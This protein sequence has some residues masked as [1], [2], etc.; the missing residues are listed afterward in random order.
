[1]KLVR[2]LV[3]PL[4]ACLLGAV[5]SAD[6]S[7]RWRSGN[8]FASELPEEMPAAAR[9]VIETWAEWT[10][11]VG[12]RMT[13]SEDG[14]V[15]LIS[16]VHDKRRGRQMKLI[17]ETIRLFDRE[18]PA[19]AERKKVGAPVAD[20]GV[21]E[22]DPLP[23]DPEGDPH[24]WDDAG[25]GGG[26]A[27]EAGWFTWATWGAG[28]VPPDT[29]TVVLFVVRNPEDQAS[30]LGRLAE[31]APYLA[32][33]IEVAL[34]HSGFVLEQPLAGAWVESM[35]QKEEWHPDGELVNRVARLLLLRRFG[36]LPHWFEQGFAW[37]AEIELR[38]GVFC[39]PY[40]R[41][42]VFAT[43][44]TDWD[45]VVRGRLA[46]R[47]TRPLVLDE[48]AAWPPHTYS[49]TFGK[50]AW[51]AVTFLLH[52]H[53]DALPALLESFRVFRDADDRVKVSDSEWHRD[54]DYSI[55]LDV[56]ARLLHEHLVPDWLEQ[57]TR[58][59]REER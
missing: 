13:L 20:A 31:I 3:G 32:D 10:G 33:W 39:F 49:D 25:G 16:P 55:P 12:S 47:A 19:P 50:L 51:G 34:Q 24:P 44:H 35:S 43:E 59:L 5:T 56:Q 11:R 54:P 14:R 36:R 18:L 28:A 26:G 30:L 17:E 42:F 38:G 40:R 29:E 1:M 58:F 15:L 2:T 8:H 45:A 41:E 4:L 9:S 22:S 52:A 6:V 7:V 21:D 46:T 57:A 48:F 27:D 53:P 23:D 37:H